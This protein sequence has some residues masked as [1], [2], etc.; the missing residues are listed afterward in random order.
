MRLDK[1]LGADGCKEFFYLFNF[2]ILFHFLAS[3][4]F[5]KIFRVK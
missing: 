4:N 2:I 1:F 5:L 3:L